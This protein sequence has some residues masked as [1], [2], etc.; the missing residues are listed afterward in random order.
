MMINLFKKRIFYILLII[1]PIGMFIFININSQ[2]YQKP[3]VTY[4]NI[5]S[6]KATT[7]WGVT[8]AKVIT[9]DNQ[10]LNNATIDTDS[11]H[12]SIS[13]ANKIKK[14]YILRTS[15]GSAIDVSVNKQNIQY[16]I[17]TNYIPAVLLTLMAFLILLL[18]GIALDKY[19]P[20]NR[21]LFNKKE[22]V[23]SLH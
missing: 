13:D 12:I 22:L 14:L 20:G 21:T 3:K 23:F 6:I 15:N 2:N 5:K 7:F 4:E 9:N 11:F 19:L 10:I 1:L 8:S 16:T 18:V 17:N